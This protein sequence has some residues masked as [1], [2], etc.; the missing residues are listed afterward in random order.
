MAG[1]LAALGVGR[2]LPA[3]IFLVLISIRDW[4]D[5]KAIV[6]L[7]GLGKLKK[8]INVLIGTWTRDLQACSIVPQAAR[9]PRDPNYFI[10]ITIITIYCLSL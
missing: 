5:P 9:L 1:R 2:P 7:E 3:K 4:V 10:I 6:R 8:K